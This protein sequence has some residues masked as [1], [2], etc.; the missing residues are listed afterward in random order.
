MTITGPGGIGNTR[1]ALAVVQAI[2]CLFS[3]GVCRVELVGVAR[4]DDVASTLLRALAITPVGSESIV[5]APP[6]FDEAPQVSSN[7]GA[8]HLQRAQ[9]PKLKPLRYL[10]PHS[11]GSSAGA[12]VLTTGLVTPGL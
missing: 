2:R 6:C 3:D 11:G 8:L 4:P 12:G 7:P 10:R 5:E 9:H 1:V